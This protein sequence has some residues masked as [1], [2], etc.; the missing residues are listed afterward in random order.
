ME[1]NTTNV[2][3]GQAP[4]NGQPQP[5]AGTSTTQVVN[6]TPNTSTIEQLQRELAE[7]RKEAAK[8][9]TERKKQEEAAQAA[10]QERLKAQ[11]EFQQL[12]EQRQA[13]VQQLEQEIAQ[14]DAEIAKRD[15]ESLRT[16]VASKHGL[17]VE[18]ASRLVGQDEQTL[19]NDATALKKLIGDQTRSLPGNAPGPRPIGQLTP[20]QEIESLKKRFASE[21]GRLL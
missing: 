15:Y 14:R 7:T 20:Q 16:K 10:E 19:E 6:E 13:R 9:R 1:D 5:Q 3:G 18:M 21:R 12:A 11:G 2:D 4:T 8:Y 17:P